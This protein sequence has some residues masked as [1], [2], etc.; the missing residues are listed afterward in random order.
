M[1]SMLSS[2]LPLVSPRFSRRFNIDS[3]SVVKN[4]TRDDLQTWEQRIFRQMHAK[5]LKETTAMVGY[6]RLPQI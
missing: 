1:L 6:E 4:S 5:L 3:S 2:S